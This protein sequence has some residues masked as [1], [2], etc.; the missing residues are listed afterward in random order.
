MARW[1]HKVKLRQYWDSDA[2]DHDTI[3][4]I[5]RK[6]ADAID[7]YPCLNGFNADTFRNIPQGDA[8]FTPSDYF[9]RR[10]DKLYDYCDRNGI[11]ID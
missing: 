7:G 5:G 8:D 10:L 3:S 6:L 4:R 1:N 11:W 2:T 9:N